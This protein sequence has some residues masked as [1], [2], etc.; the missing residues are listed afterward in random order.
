[1]K[2]RGNIILTYFSAWVLLSVLY[3]VLLWVVYAIDFRWAVSDSLVST[4]LLFVNGLA[5]FFM[6]QYEDHKRY[7]KA[8]SLV[9]MLFG[10][11]V[12]LSLFYI[13]SDP[14]LQYFAESDSHYM[15]FYEISGIPRLLFA[16]MMLLLMLVVFKLYQNLRAL[17]E[18]TEQSL[19]LQSM[20]QQSELN[21]LR[22]QIN[23]HFLFNSLNSV[24]SLTESNPRQA[25][26]MIIKLSDLLRYSLRK[27]EE[28][29][30]TLA[31]EIQHIRLYTDIEKVRFGDRLQ[32]D[33]QASPDCM[34]MKLP[35]LMLQPLIENAVKHGVYSTEK[36]SVIKVSCEPQSHFLLINIENTYD[37]EGRTRAGT[38]TGLRNTAE[39]MRL[40]YNDD[41]LFKVSD[42]AHVFSVTIKIPQS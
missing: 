5:L 39:R 21:A 27:S 2:N 29:T 30:S 41:S 18:K 28:S 6:I 40:T 33:I 17:R 42:S 9:Q 35:F 32:V 16:A 26:E 37:P 11:F 7:S 31:L 38:G 19:R 10:Y 22:W 12:A 36:L 15:E 14:L 23:P 20:L 25:R 4:S 24:S 34:N 3:A 1:M 13:V 8:R